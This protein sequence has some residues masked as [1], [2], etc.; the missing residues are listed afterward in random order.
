MVKDS[1]ARRLMRS[2]ATLAIGISLIAGCAQS[3]PQN[4]AQPEPAAENTTAIAE[5]PVDPIATRDILPSWDQKSEAYQRL[6]SFVESVVDPTSDQYLPPEERI[7]T[8]D[9]DGTFLCEKAPTYFD[10]CFSLWHALHDPA[11]EAPA[12]LKARSEAMLDEFYTGDITPE[13][14]PELNYTLAEAYTGHEPEELA[15]DVLR[16]AESVDV[17][18]F[19]GMKYGESFYKPMLEVIDYLRANDF[20][21]WVVSASERLVARPICV[22][23]AGFAPD[24]VIG[25]DL[26]VRAANQDTADGLDYTLEQ[27][28]ELLIGGGMVSETGS[29][30]KPIAILNEIGCRPII[31]FGNSSGDYAMLNYTVTNPDHEGIGFLVLCD[32]TARE[33]GDLVRAAK[34]E[35]EA[36]DSKWVTISM[37][38]DWSTIYGEGVERTQLASTHEEAVKLDAAA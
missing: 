17:V 33:Y 5:Q 19:S 26:I 24:H 36:E 8:T 15:S 32:D 23:Y 10:Q 22:S 11:Y 35:K 6:T 25:S 4:N 38:N 9:M 21:V 37:A 30:N 31:A 12:D 27:D 7:V 13:H 34:Q 3:A 2:L 14:G 29:T 20:D 1:F 18:G 16:F 28:E